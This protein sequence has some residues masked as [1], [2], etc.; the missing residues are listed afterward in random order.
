MRA[1]FAARPHF[2][3]DTAEE[4][5]VYQKF[6]AFFDKHHLSELAQNDLLRLI[7][8]YNCKLLPANGANFSKKRKEH[9]N[10]VSEKAFPLNIHKTRV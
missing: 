10:L 5:E 1:F 6:E 9:D 7:H 2:P 8:K 4:L 3:C